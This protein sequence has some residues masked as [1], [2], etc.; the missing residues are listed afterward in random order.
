MKY[1][2]KFFEANSMSDF[3][4][5]LNDYLVYFE[6]AGYEVRNNIA[7]G[8]PTFITS[9]NPVD[10]IEIKADFETLIDYLKTKPFFVK[11][12]D[13]TLNVKTQDNNPLVYYMD[14]DDFYKKFNVENKIN[15]E[16]N[17]KISL[18][19]LYV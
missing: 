2:K 6:D 14:F 16:D 12:G 1:L 3:Q 17:D 11:R 19:S 10:Y 5:E 9:D 7:Y 4:N 15:F 8:S 18:I 13:I